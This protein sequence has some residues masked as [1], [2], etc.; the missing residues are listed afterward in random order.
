MVLV[1]PKNPQKLFDIDNLVCLADKTVI[2]FIFELVGP[3]TGPLYSVQLY[4]EFSEKLSQKHLSENPTQTAVDFL[5]VN[6]HGRQTFLVKRTL[7][8][9]D[10]KMDQIMSKKGCDA[11]NMFDEEVFETEQDFSDDEM[12]RAVKL[13]KK[14][15][16]RE[17]RQKGLAMSESEDSENNQKNQDEES[18][19]DAD[20]VG[21]QLEEGEISSVSYARKEYS[22]NVNQ[23]NQN[24]LGSQQKRRR[25]QLYEERGKQSYAQPANGHN[26]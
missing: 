15:A 20:G 14:K 9:I 2:G 13:A 3:I 11:S 16:R 6:L 25:M 21:V 4:P 22:K 10:G 12:E 8:T 23:A 18:K 26:S 7:K 5:K 1:E 17:A 19:N 24:N